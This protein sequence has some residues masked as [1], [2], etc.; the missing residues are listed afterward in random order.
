VAA[1]GGQPSSGYDIAIER[2]AAGNGELK[3][4]VL[5]T[6]PELSCGVL[7]VVTSPVVM[8]RVPRSQDDVQFIEKSR[9]VPCD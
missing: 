4:Y 5:T 2:V 1:Q 6:S 9:I 8:V 3:V 7:T